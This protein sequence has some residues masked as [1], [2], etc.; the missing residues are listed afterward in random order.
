MSLHLNVRLNK[1]AWEMIDIKTHLI[2]L[3]FITGFQGIF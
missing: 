2:M 1:D 3:Y